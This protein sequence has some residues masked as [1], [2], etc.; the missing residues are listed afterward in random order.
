M[1]AA[2]VDQLLRRHLD[3]QIDHLVAVVRKNNLDQVLADI[4][5]VAFDRGEQHLA[6]RGRVG[7]FHV[8]LQMRHCGL[9]RLGRL[10]HFGDDQLV[11]VEQPADFV[12]SFHQRPVDDVERGGP[13]GSLLFQILDQPVLGA[14]DD[15][16]C[17]PFIERQVRIV[18]PRM[19]LL[20][21]TSPKVLGDGGDVK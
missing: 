20:G 1:L 18:R 6:A 7:L 2:G 8:L 15:E 16:V 21:G 9:H 14:L 17:Q 19:L 4:V 12:H 3:A 5:H 13:F 11:V 10:Q